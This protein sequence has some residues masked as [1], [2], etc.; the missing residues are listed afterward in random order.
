MPTSV[1]VELENTSAADTPAA[2][3]WV[4]GLASGTVAL[5][6]LTT[7]IGCGVGD[8]APAPDA[9]SA[10]VAG[11]AGAAGA[12]DGTVPPNFSYARPVLN[13]PPEPAPTPGAEPQHETDRDWA[14]ARGTVAW[15]RSQGLGALPVVELVALLGPT[16]VGAPYEPGTLEIPG[17]ER[18][19]VNLRTFDCVT[20]VEHVLVMARLVRDPTVNPADPAVDPGADAAFRARY[21]DELTRLRYRGGV[22]DGYASRLHYFTEWMDDAAEKGLVD[23]ITERLGGVV[24][25]RPIHFMTSNPNAYRQLGEDP[26]LLPLIRSAEERLSA[27]TRWMIPEARIADIEQGIQS[28]DLIAAVSTLD[29]LDIAHT[30]IAI[31]HEGRIHL[32]H[33]PL[34]GDSVEISLVPLAERIQG[35]SRQSGIRV[36]RPRDLR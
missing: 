29:G 12:A 21:R 5:L 16:F 3:R 11:A 14:I 15:A 18:L 31:R 28:G 8:G 17:T 27:R 4:P 13:L 7:L 23:D 2:H 34:V 24:D 1:K 19:V 9:G 33:A 6:F 35:L 26:S 30:G 32:L 36:V 10:G 20:F 25:P 22:L